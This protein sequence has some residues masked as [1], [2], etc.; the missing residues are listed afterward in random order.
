MEL[1]FHQALFGYDGGHQLLAASL[2]LPTEARHSLAVA[3]DIS[4]S[5]PTC[6]FDQT[7]TGMPLA[8][9]EFYALFCTWLAPEMPRPG[10]VWSHVLLI[11]LPDLAELRDLGAL[12]S[13][14]VR[15]V[16][17]KE[18]DGFSKPLHYQ[19]APERPLRLPPN[20]EPLA[21]ILIEALYTEANRPVVLAETDA[22][23][24]EELIF[25]LWSQQWP[26]LRRN[27]VFST[28]SFA[29]RGRN[30]PAFDV[31]VTPMANLGAWPRS[32]KHLIIAPQTKS[33]EVE[34][35]V[36]EVLNDLSA[37]NSRGLRSFM[38]EY[39]LDLISPRGSFVKLVRA[40]QQTRHISPTNWTQI[41][42][43]IA[44]DFPDASDAVRLK[45]WMISPQ[46][47]VKEQDDL[48]LGWA[49][50]SFLLNDPIALA[51]DSVSYN[52]LS[53]VT[54]LWHEKRKD[55]LELFANLV[56][57]DATPAASNFASAI[58]N[59]VNPEDLRE[60]WEIRPELLSP[61]ISHR[62]NIAFNADIWRLPVSAQWRALEAL[63]RAKLSQKDWGEVLGAMLVAETDTAVNE[64]VVK[65][66]PFA[67]EA[68]LRWAERGGIRDRLPSSIWREALGSSAAD[69][70]GVMPL[71]P[72]HLALCAWLAPSDVARQIAVVRQDIQELAREA[73]ENLPKPLLLPTSFF[74]MTLG[75][76]SEGI[77]GL[78]L[79]ARGF[80]LVHAALA[81][82]NYPWESWQLLSPLL[83]H[84]DWFR[85][86]DK[87]EK[88]RRAV[89]DW[90]ANRDISRKTFYKTAKTLGIQQTPEL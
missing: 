11:E 83:P 62:P 29:D 52:H 36:R 46:I 7:Y 48:E 24:N 78:L 53:L 35:W 81:A 71:P 54:R 73:I 3:T 18:L 9:T 14:F 67:I 12:R 77:E 82:D 55:L 42:Q 41:L 30:G 39:G 13:L 43:S 85:D 25:S 57:Q 60:I 79:I 69:R 64:S 65:A 58:T 21:V 56:R 2:R 1:T 16:P 28:G 89:Q 19:S 38:S 63:A 86:W 8:G 31:Q 70:L 88:L 84:L 66:G 74:L 75:L 50:I 4:G 27:F 87:C 44:Q 61:I 20:S 76:R 51:Y 80:A 32:G 40:F 72:L 90:L 47:F 68:A 49:I 22:C 17:P 6:K 15:P 33:Q 37:P 59:V 23:A 10:C 34:S 45:Q 26:R 5:A